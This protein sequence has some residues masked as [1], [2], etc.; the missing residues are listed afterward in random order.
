MSL[1]RQVLHSVSKK[2]APLWS[3][4]R[5]NFGIDHSSPLPVHLVTQTV[6]EEV[7]IPQKLAR[8]EDVQLPSGDDLGWR[9]LGERAGH[10]PDD[11]T[12]A[13]NNLS[14]TADKEQRIRE[15]ADHFVDWGDVLVGFEQAYR[16]LTTSFVAD[17]EEALATWADAVTP[18]LGQLLCDSR[19]G[20]A[21]A[22][23]V[24]ER[25][26]APAHVTP[27]VIGARVEL[28]T[29][30]TP[31]EIFGIMTVEEVADQFWRGVRGPECEQYDW[32]KMPSRIVVDVL[33][34]SHERSRLRGPDE[35]AWASEG[36]DLHIAR[37]VVTL[38]SNLPCVGRAAWRA[39]ERT[40]W[41]WRVRNWNGVLR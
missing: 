10:D 31:G 35:P 9:L 1:T 38:E 21:A 32:R 14:R 2:T 27:V 16:C 6:V 25:V 30:S 3:L 37:N 36:V 34:R 12:R 26:H 13:F 17:E 19:L 40:A 5:L 39:E 29:A 23:V 33:V 20:H 18:R 15:L 11:I 7:I 24:P 22:G 28:G 41:T 4:R 8:L